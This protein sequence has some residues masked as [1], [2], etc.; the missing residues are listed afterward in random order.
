MDEDWIGRAVSIKCD[1]KLGVFQGMI[2][3]ISVEHITIIR[4]FRNGVPLRKQDAE[5]TLRAQ[6]I[7]DIKLIPS[8]NGQ[9][10]VTPTV[11]NKPTPVKQPNFASAPTS[12]AAVFEGN[13]SLPVNG[14]GSLR[15][16]HSALTNKISNMKIANGYRKT[17]T[18]ERFPKAPTVSSSNINGITSLAAAVASTSSI[19]NGTTNNRTP[20]TTNSVAQF[21]GNLIP[22]KVEVR[23]GASF[24]A[25][26]TP[27]S[28]GSMSKPID[29]VNANRSAS[30]NTNPSSS[31]NGNGAAAAVAAMGGNANGNKQLNR[32]NLNKQ[33]KKCRREG[34]LKQNQT[35]GTSVDDPIMNEDFD[36]EGNLALFD[37]QALWD[38]LEAEQKPD[39]VRQAVSVQDKK[40]RHDENILEGAPL[41]LRQIETLFDGSTDFVTDEGLIVPTIPIYV[42]LKIEQAAEACGL[43]VQRQNDILAR[44]TT[45]LAI[46]LLGGARR[47]TPNN[48]HQWPTIAIICDKSKNFR[49]SEIGAATGRQLASH[50][51]K[52]LLFLQ[53]DPSIE[54]NST[55]VLLFKATG[56]T[57]VYSVEALPTPDLVILSTCSDNVSSS[58]S[59]WLKENRAS[60][61]AIDPPP[62]G[63]RDVPIK[64]SILPTLPLNG[65][66][67]NCGKLYLCNLG[68]P[69]KF[70][71]DAGIKYKSPFGHKF[72]IPI[73]MKD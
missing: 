71:R 68:I 52:V 23:M 13:N 70:Y 19:T 72:V 57:I 39:L 25:T 38:V 62:N 47:L 8:F 37:K 50:G 29:I 20:P 65:I 30:V 27:E 44:G 34:S 24:A 31:F 10:T 55:E 54:R 40:Y 2:K 46:L 9:S 3:D 5:I 51:L 41:Q 53:E 11:I 48:C 15:E 7:L 14:V 43:S 36:F 45:D 61:L 17:P 59:K 60:I 33:R 12:A 26:T 42:R 35:F 18:S 28:F 4:A 56:N 64:Y 67:T 22:P 73:H 21:F 63:I 69:D 32:A 66:S 49:V 16:S 6:D 1:D 58:V